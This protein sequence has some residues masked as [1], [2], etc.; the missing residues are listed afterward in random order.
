M[1]QIADSICVSSVGS[2]CTLFGATEQVSAIVESLRE[3]GIEI[4]AI[5]DN[6]QRKWGTVFVG[7]AVAEPSVE[8]L[9]GR[10]VLVTSIPSY[11]AIA[12]QLESFGLC[13][14]RDFRPLQSEPFPLALREDLAQLQL[15]VNTF[16]L[17]GRFVDA[18]RDLLERALIWWQLC[19]DWIP[20]YLFSNKPLSLL[21]VGA[22]NG[23]L[24]RIF[25]Q[26]GHS[27]RGIDFSSHCEAGTWELKPI[28]ELQQLP[29]HCHDAGSLPYPFEEQSFDLV[30]CFATITRVAEPERWHEIL[31]E[32]ARLSRHGLLL[33]CNDGPMF[34]GAG[35]DAIQ[36]WKPQSLERVRCSERIF[37]YQRSQPIS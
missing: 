33:G 37:K 26:R 13:E 12:N 17:E 20:E 25:K 24:M 19:Q 31:D 29:V 28:V 36:K 30:V 4:A 2:R 3:R 14:E 6:D 10:H 1:F 23:V 7:L 5:V 11:R 9:V 32:F 16:P 22:G 15:K 27:P 8:L 34:R 35:R 21:D 18:Y